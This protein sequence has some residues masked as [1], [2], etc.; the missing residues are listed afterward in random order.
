MQR[1]QNNSQSPVNTLTSRPLQLYLSGNEA[2]GDSGAAALA[3]ALKTSPRISLSQP[4]IHTLDLSSCAIGDTGAEALATAIEGNPGCVHVLDLSNN[5]ITDE[6]AVALGRALQRAEDHP[7]G[8][9]HIN[10]SN[11]KQIGDRGL[12]ELVLAMER[13]ALRRLSLRSCSVQAE[14][15]SAVG[16]MFCFLAAK[17]RSSAFVKPVEV[18]LSGNAFGTLQERDKSG[19]VGYSASL[20]KSKASATTASYLSFIGEKIKSGL[21]DAGLDFEGLLP[22]DDQSELDE[23]DGEQAFDNVDDRGITE[24]D[25]LNLE[26]EALDIASQFSAP[27]CGARAFADAVLDFACNKDEQPH[28][29]DQQLSVC[30]FALGMRL[31]SLDSLAADALA[32]VKLHLKNHHH[33]DLHVDVGLNKNIGS[34]ALAAL[35]GSHSTLDAA[36]LEEMSQRH[37]EAR[38]NIRIARERAKQAA[39]AES[40]RLRAEDAMSGMIGSDHEDDISDDEVDHFS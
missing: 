32:A 35:S 2:V 28:V 10:L 21:K 6:G 33:S 1:F 17:R 22:S 39:E 38:E 12:S 14:G 30:Q 4:V 36:F 29:C 40:A 8:L 25:E 5:K 37:L 20:L 16:R 18:D 9:D 19:I 3:A 13:E 7:I 26:T 31:C 24:T 34:T 11:N 27:K 15:A 23:E